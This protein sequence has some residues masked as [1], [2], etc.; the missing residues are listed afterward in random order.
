[1]HKH[2]AGIYSSTPP[3]NTLETID[4]EDQKNYL[5]G[6]PPVEIDDHPAGVGTIETY[7]IVHAKDQSPSYAVL[8]GRTARGHRFIAQTL[9]DPEVFQQLSSQSMVGESVT[10]RFDRER[11][12]TLALF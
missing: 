10:L 8:Y 12:L 9:S 6:P 4:L 5:T 2:A 11:K 7:T 1:M 3:K